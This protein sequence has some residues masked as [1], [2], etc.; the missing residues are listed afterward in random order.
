MLARLWGL[1]VE[2][3]PLL[4]RRYCRNV[5]VLEVTIL[6]EKLI[7]LSDFW[8]IFLRLALCIF[9]TSWIRGAVREADSDKRF[10]VL[11]VKVARVLVDI[12]HRTALPHH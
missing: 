11:W 2:T 3:E 1:K 9:Q 4:P 6:K 12:L 8:G 7:C 5:A 10:V